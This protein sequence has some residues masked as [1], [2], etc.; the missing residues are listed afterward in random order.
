[1]IKISIARTCKIEKKALLSFGTWI[2]S[3]RCPWLTGEARGCEVP[4][5]GN[6]PMG[7]VQSFRRAEQLTNDW[8]DFSPYRHYG[9]PLPRRIIIH[10]DHMLTVP[11]G[12][13]LRFWFQS[14]SWN[15]PKSTFFFYQIS[16][17]G[18]YKYADRQSLCAALTR[19][20][21]SRWCWVFS[22]ELWMVAN[23]DDIWS[24]VS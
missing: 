18:G 13:F 15:S 16:E 17:N 19:N 9:D 23:A 24:D 21:E 12:S 1:M 22:N 8:Y 6:D 10:T 4:R 20:F 14:A 2:S 7:N 5:L 11:E 3:S